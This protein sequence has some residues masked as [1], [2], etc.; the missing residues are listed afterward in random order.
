MCKRD[1]D[2]GK[3]VRENALVQLESAPFIPGASALLQIAACNAIALLQARALRAVTY[4]LGALPSHLRA[5]VAA[6]SM[7]T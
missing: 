1:Q 2:F 3:I 7:C 5:Q 6:K 4:K